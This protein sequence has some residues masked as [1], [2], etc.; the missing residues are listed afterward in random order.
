MSYQA[1]PSFSHLVGEPGQYYHNSMDDWLREAQRQRELS[2]LR[3]IVRAHK[4]SPVEVRDEDPPR[5]E[6]VSISRCYRCNVY[7]RILEPC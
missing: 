7:H 2:E 4:A 1:R 5:R 6:V 3:E